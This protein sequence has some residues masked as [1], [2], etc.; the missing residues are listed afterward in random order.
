MKRL[1]A[2]MIVLMLFSA[3]AAALG[4]SPA[5]HARLAVVYNPDPADRLNLRAKPDKSAVSL[6]KFYS[7]TPVTVLGTSGGFAQVTL[8]GS[9][10]GYMDMDYLVFCEEIRRDSPV[11]SAMPVVTV[12]APL[13]KTIHESMPPFSNAGLLVPMGA[14]LEVMGVAEDWLFVR[15]GEEITGFT[16]NSG[17]APRLYFSA[18]DITPAAP[19][20]LLPPQTPAPAGEYALV[21]AEVEGARR[22]SEADWILFAALSEATPLYADRA[23]TKPIDVLEQ[24]KLLRLFNEMSTYATVVLDGRIAG[25]IPTA[26]HR[27]MLHAAQWPLLITRPS[28]MVSNPLPNDRLHLRQSPDKSARSLGR[29]YTG[30]VV[31]L[32]DNLSGQNEWTHVEICGVEGYMKSE[33]LDFSPVLGEDLPELHLFEIKPPA[34]GEMHLRARPDTASE[35]LGRL[36]NGM[37]AAVIGV[38][39]DWAHVVCEGQAGYLL[40]RCLKTSDGADFDPR[41]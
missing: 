19:I 34:A 7:G 10:R 38:T 2:L 39:G 16:S 12:T 4:D 3:A 28:A 31:A 13:G 8:C 18:P 41:L 22:V 40:H 6:G 23:L 9:L 20:S 29:Y 35:S 11:K 5:D 27:F 17:T 32:L 25:Y 14:R 1:I 24:G 21:R 30:T 15:A 37:L 26:P 33:Y 36:E